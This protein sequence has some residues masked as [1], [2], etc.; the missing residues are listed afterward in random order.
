M[1]FGNNL[2]HLSVPEW[3]S[4]NI[5]YND[6]K[7]KIKQIT[8]QDTQDLSLLQSA[9]IENI[10][11]VNL[12]IQTKYGELNR[13]FA[14]LESIFN[15][16]LHLKDEI[17]DYDSLRSFLI[18]IDELFYQ[19]LELSIILKNLSKFI[20]IQKIAIKK[21]FKKFL[22]YYQ[23][24]KIGT[25]FVV[26]LKDN[27]LIKNPKSFINFDLTKLTLKLTNLINLIKY[28]RKVVEC[29]NGDLHRKNSLFSIASS[30]NTASDYQNSI[31]NNH[32]A[33]TATATA[34]TTQLIPNKNG[35]FATTTATGTTNSSPNT[36]TTVTINTN[37]NTNASTNFYNS[38]PQQFPTSP[39]AHFDLTVLLKRN[40][41]CHCL[42]PA[43]LTNDMILNFNVYLNLK[44]IED[45]IISA[46]Y[47]NQDLLKEPAIILSSDTSQSSIVLAPTGGLRKNSYCILP[48]EIVEVFLAHLQDRSNEEYKT[49]LYDYFQDSSQ[50]TKK[51]INYIVA[52]DY[53]PVSR[54]FCQRS[55]FRIDKHSGELN[56]GNNNEILIDQTGS[57]TLHQ[58]SQQQQQQQQQPPP[59]PPLDENDYYI[60]LES[61]VSTTNKPKH[62][63]TVVFPEDFNEMDCFPHGHLGIYSNDLNLSEFESSLVT[64][65]DS[66]T[67]VL[68]NKHSPSFARRFPKKLQMILQN[69]AVSLY[70]G[71]NFYQYQI[72]CYYNIVPNGEFINNHYTNLLNLNLLKEFENIDACNQ[73]LNQEEDLIRAKSDNIMKHKMSIQNLQQQ[74]QV[75]QQQ[76]QQQKRRIQ[77]YLHHQHP[78]NSFGSSIFENV[79]RDSG[80]LSLHEA[81]LSDADV[82]VDVVGADND[83]DDEV[84]DLQ[85]NQVTNFLVSILNLKNKFLNQG[86]TDSLKSKPNHHHKRQ[87]FINENPY[88]FAEDA[89][90]DEHEHLLDPYTKLLSIYHG[91]KNGNNNPY[92]AINLNYSTYDSINEEP[93][94]FFQRNEYQLKYE[95]NYDQTLSYIY[96]TLTIISLFLCGIQLGT[97]YSIFSSIGNIEDS[98]F[99]IRDNLGIFVVLVLGMIISVGFNLLAINLLWFRYSDPVKFHNFAVSGALVI[100]LVGCV[101]SCALLLHCF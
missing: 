30:L 13:K 12:F 17:N 82:V 40:F 70:K 92:D 94:S 47:L 72:S 60:T 21:I 11:Y 48:N 58:P 9:F 75:I 97:I 42:V 29:F 69:N 24:K 96:L 56:G 32:Q 89:V 87:H 4:Y 65:V 53:L 31:L 27:L 67:G 35:T 79:I 73:Q 6:L 19:A 45:N 34:T 15:N 90:H 25:K 2:Q 77:S 99:L 26:D 76:D 22:K 14:Y 74:D 46:I 98:K 55:R 59:P 51:T 61:N 64:E 52:N 81:N 68:R 20:L 5:D 71:F 50:L 36:A 62:I 38:N 18:E 95:S 44:C 57:S 84:M 54:T 43:D 91:N 7:Y 80:S 85:N 49:R 16:L 8:K 66:Q 37:T 83:A 10:D 86:E 101:W 23:Y 88:Y 100:N 39:E 78:Q 3:K 63:N 41:Q 1:K 28:E 93:M 33:A